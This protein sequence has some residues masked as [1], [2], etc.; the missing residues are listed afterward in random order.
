MRAQIRNEIEQI[1]PFDALERMHRLDA[2]AWVDSGVELCRR[3]KPATPPKHLVSYVVIAD[4]GH[5]LLVDHKNAQLWLPPGG[6][7][8]PQEHPRTT[9]ERELKEELGLT[10]SHPISDPL[11][12]TVTETIGHTAGHMDISLWYAVTARRGQLFEFDRD[13]FESV[14][15]FAFDDVPPDRADPHLLRFLRKFTSQ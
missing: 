3:D 2:L 14:C 5:I 13:E 8:E 1:K 11:F 6:R 15:W 9:V 4:D 10:A 7:V 12:V